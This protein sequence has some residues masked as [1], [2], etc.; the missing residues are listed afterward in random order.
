MS[1][2]FSKKR[3]ISTPFSYPTYEKINL[4]YVCS[5]KHHSRL[6]LYLYCKYTKSF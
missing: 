3:S 6:S 1:R 5:S 2:R 4:K